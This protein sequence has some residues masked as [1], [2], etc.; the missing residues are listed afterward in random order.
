[1][2]KIGSARHERKGKRQTVTC[3]VAF[4]LVTKQ[5]GRQVEWVV[6]VCGMS[7]HC[8]KDDL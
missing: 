8:V 6:L 4:S 7:I 2:S 1:M 5:S 3:K